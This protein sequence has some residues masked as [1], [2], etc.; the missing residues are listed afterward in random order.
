MQKMTDWR[1]G[2]K[3]IR[4]IGYGPQNVWIRKRN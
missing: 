2:D 4:I 1:R 3:K